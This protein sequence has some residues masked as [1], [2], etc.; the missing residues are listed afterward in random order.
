MTK[1]VLFR[2]RVMREIARLE[3]AAWARVGGEGREDACRIMIHYDYSATV[4][5]DEE[6]RQM[7]KLASGESW[8][9]GMI[10]RWNAGPER[11]ITISRAADKEHGYVP[12]PRS[13]Y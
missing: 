9:Y 2:A 11:A 8:C 13:N 10:S 1:R 3:S 5:T 4:I 7:A 12:K 6:A